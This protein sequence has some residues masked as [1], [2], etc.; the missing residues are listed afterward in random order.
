LKVLRGKRLVA[1]YDFGE[2][3]TTEKLVNVVLKEDS[4]YD[5]RFITAVINSPVP[6][7][8]VEKA[9]FSDTTETSRVMD[10]DYSGPIPIPKSVTQ[11]EQKRIIEL[12]KKMP[13][14][15]KRLNEI[16]DKRTDERQRIEEEIKKT[17]AEID[18]SVYELYGITES[19]KRI[20]EDSF[21]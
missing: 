11:L 6:S 14:L 21:G 12:V 20:I 19:E 10:A 7:F 3:V 1:D 4:G 8:Y 17:G 15:N 16:G 18:E 2:V 9:L 13:S 5:I